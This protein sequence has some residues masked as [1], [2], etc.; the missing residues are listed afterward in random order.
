MIKLAKLPD[1]TPIKLTIALP[2]E[3][4][5]ALQS[6]ASVYSQTYGREER[7]VDWIPALLSSFLDSDRAF[8]RDRTGRRTKDA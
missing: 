3:L 8:A 4:S 7:I 5:E 2:P 1:R 6:Y